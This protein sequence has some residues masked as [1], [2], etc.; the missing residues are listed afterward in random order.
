MDKLANKFGLNHIW[1]WP[2]YTSIIINELNK[3]LLILIRIEVDIWIEY[4]PFIEKQFIDNL[5]HRQVDFND[6]QSFYRQSDLVIVVKVGFRIK[7][8][9]NAVIKKKL[10]DNRVVNL[11]VNLL[12]FTNVNFI[13]TDANYLLCELIENVAILLHYYLYQINLNLMKLIQ[14]LIW[15]NLIDAGKNCHMIR[16]ALKLYCNLQMCRVNYSK[17]QCNLRVSKLSGM[18]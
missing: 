4:G 7:V 11:N 13:V 12:Y 3:P 15:R 18:L 9:V 5:F 10:V 16:L 8:K 14:T 1:S 2:L 17:L 6:R